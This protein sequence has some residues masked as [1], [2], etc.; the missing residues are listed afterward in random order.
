MDYNFHFDVI[1]LNRDI[2]AYG[3]WLTVRISL[4]STALGLL[5]GIFLAGLQTTRWKL[6]TVPP[7]TPAG[8]I[9]RKNL[10]APYNIST[11]AEYEYV[12]P[13][14]D[15]EVILASIWKDVLRVDK[16]NVNDNFFD[17]GGK[18]L[19]SLQVI[20]RINEKFKMKL[21][22]RILLL[23][24]LGQIAAQLDQELTLVKFDRHDRDSTTSKNRS[25]A[26]RMLQ[27]FKKY[28]LT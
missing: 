24:T 19:L 20:Q 27:K 16:V 18:S 13:S 1:W 28:F 21:S 26:N 23:N 12:S 3:A 7:I 22:P 5:V 11:S 8:K 14:T 15:T 6:F 9:D 25:F 4:I 10:P 17:I 2:L